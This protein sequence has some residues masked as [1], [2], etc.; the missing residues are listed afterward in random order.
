MKKL[1]V[2]PRECL[3]V[4]NDAIEDMVARSLGMN[5]FL[6]TDCLVNREN[7][8]ISQF[9]NGNFDDLSKYIEKGCFAGDKAYVPEVRCATLGYHAGII[10]AANLV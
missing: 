7:L 9:P 2:D 10:G 5:V 3:M 1:N 6:V 8:D 4:G